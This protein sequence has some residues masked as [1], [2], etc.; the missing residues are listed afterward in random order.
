MEKTHKIGW[1][2][3]PGYKG[4]TWNPIVGCSKISEGCNNCYAEKMANR[5]SKIQKTSDKYCHSINPETGKWNGY[6]NGFGDVVIKPLHWRK[7]RVIFVC[8]MGDLFHEKVPFKWIDKVYRTMEDVDVFDK[9]IFVILTKRAERMLEYITYRKAKGMNYGHSWIWM[10]VTT[11]NQEQANK[12]I[13]FLLET[14]AAVKFVSIEPMLGPIKLNRLKEGIA[15]ERNSLNGE[16]YSLGETYQEGPKLDWVIV[17]GES[18]HHARPM[19]PD[20]VRSVRDQCAKANTP[21]FFKQWGEWAPTHELL[22]NRPG[23][24]GKLWHNFDPDTSVCKLGRKNTGNLLDN[25]RHEDFPLS[26]LTT[27]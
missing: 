2:N 1:L 24:K 16:A 21:F 9:H 26:L 10:G 5:L 17:G 11:E 7:P 14:E 15:L 20:W 25:R 13:P 27:K 23:L 12:R 19:H 3:L 18:G 8:S 4:E 6:V 22:C